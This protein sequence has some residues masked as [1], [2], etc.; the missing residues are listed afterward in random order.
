[1][2]MQTK[3]KLIDDDDLETL[4]V[5]NYLYVFSDEN[6]VEVRVQSK[7]QLSE[8]EIRSY[9]SVNACLEEVFCYCERTGVKV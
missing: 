4:T 5:I 1:M 6:D 9:V 2:Q 3:I 7:E 8:K